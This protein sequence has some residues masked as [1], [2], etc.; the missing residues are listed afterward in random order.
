V[1]IVGKI[2][3]RTTAQ[4]PMTI[5]KRIYHLPG[6]ALRLTD[7]S[8]SHAP[9]ARPQKNALTTASID[10]ISWP[11]LTESILVQRISYPNPDTPDRKKST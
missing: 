10:T 9:K 6:T 1:F 8:K 5:S 4:R 2:N 11:K 7:R 3:I